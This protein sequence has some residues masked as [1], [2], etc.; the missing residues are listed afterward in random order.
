MADVRAQFLDVGTGAA[1]RRIAYVNQPGGA[2]G[3]LWLQGFRSDM[4]GTKAE[5]LSRWAGERGLACS[6]FDY[7]GHGQS[8]GRFEEG[9][10]G[11]WLD[12]ARQA[13][14]RLT[15]GPQIVVGSSMG[16]YIALLLL[17]QLM[18]EAPAEAP[19]IRALV[20]VP[21]RRA[22]WPSVSP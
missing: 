5:A 1:R 12:E 16:G 18:A 20:L 6:R 22:M 17:Q 11:R 3:L 14:A 8:G 2:P 10:I 19:R 4:T 13:F 9:T 7:S 21:Y 15:A